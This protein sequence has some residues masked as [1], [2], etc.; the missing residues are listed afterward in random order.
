MLRTYRMKLV[1]SFGLLIVVTLLAI[2]GIN[3]SHVRAELEAAS[4]ANQERMVSQIRTNIEQRMNELTRAAIRLAGDKQLQQIAEHLPDAPHEL[5]S[6]VMQRLDFE[7]RDSG[8]ST[9]AIYDKDNIDK[10]WN[11]HAPPLNEQDWARWRR[12]GAKLA[13]SR[14]PSK[15]S[16]D[17]YTKP[18]GAAMPVMLLS[19][20]IYKIKTYEALPLGVLQL[21]TQSDWITSQLEDMKQQRYGQYFITDASGKVL[22]A[23][24]SDDMGRQLD[25]PQAFA[26]QTSSG[27]AKWSSKEWIFWVQKFSAQDWYLVA[28]TPVAGVADGV[29]AALWE[30]VTVAGIIFTLSLGMAILISHTITKP[31]KLLR[32][33]M[34]QVERGMFNT[35]VQIDSADE[36]GYLG[37][38][39]NRMA[40]QIRELIANNLQTELARKEAELIAL[41]AQINP[42][43]LNNA[44]SSIDSLALQQKEPR[45]RVISQALAR[46]FRYSISGG[47]MATVE[48]ELRHVELY[49]SIQK[50]R[51]GDKLS[52]GI[53]LEEGLE[54]MEMPKLLLQPIV[55]N[56]I[57]HGLELQSGGGYVNV[58]MRSDGEER[59]IIEIEDS[60]LGMAP[61]KLKH[62]EEQ[63]TLDRYGMKQEGEVRRSIGLTNVYRRLKL[64]YEDDGGMELTSSPGFGTIIQLTLPKKAGKPHGE[65]A[66]RRG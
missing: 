48:E 54:S 65:R 59:M 60:G 63:M 24:H 51:Y 55:E 2:E 30:S 35:T 41:Q 26:E 66:D 62:L 47:A 14:S 61:E 50:I 52:Y 46:M 10:L 44:L 19:Q 22:I 23:S 57:A 64:L 32:Q 5:R 7:T 18:G 17:H 31:I 21:S 6:A 20:P 43:F 29:S 27:Q 25:D 3:Y 42:H 34:A 53:E 56:A 40:V 33:A 4:S 36:F 58:Y 8:I 11:I 49:L 37:K 16:L 15:W 39:F 12:E 38:S 13:F 28:V 1:I 45:I 9:V